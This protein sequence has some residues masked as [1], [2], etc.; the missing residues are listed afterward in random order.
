[1]NGATLGY[2]AQLWRMADAL[3]NNMDA[4]EYKHVVLGL[5]FLK[6][7]S[8]AFEERR[9]QL[10]RERDQGADPEDP[11]EYR[12][13]NVFWVP[14]EARWS[15]LQ[16]HS[17]QPTIGQRIDE[18]MT[19]IERD[20]PALKGVLPKDYARPALDK[21]RLGQLIDLI[22]NIRIGDGDMWLTGFDAPCLHTM[23]LDKPM[24]GH[25]LLQAIARVNR[26]FRDKLGGLVVDYLG[27]AQELKLALATYTESGGT[28][29]TAIDQ[30]EAVALLKEKYEICRDLLHGF[31][32]S[33][34]YDALLVNPEVKQIL[35]DQQLREIA[36][37]L[38][39]AVRQ[40][41]TIDWTMRENA[42]ARMRVMVKRILNQ[43]GYPPAQREDAAEVVLQ[44]ASLFSEEWAA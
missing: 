24:R 31:D 7:I 6:Y 27:L 8:D 19:A 2:E 5:I 12:A 16:A 9:R 39:Q 1:M 15:H 38:V 30:D 14:P 40:N 33:T 43:H 42:R 29:R 37:K 32:W 44:Q 36:R 4:A 21:T 34:C 26:V 13:E 10:E 11:D 28:G 20:N 17:K 35:N 22:T 3:R 25:G 41:I 18:A 23:Y